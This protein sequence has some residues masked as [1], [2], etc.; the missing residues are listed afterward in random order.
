MRNPMAHVISVSAFLIISF[1]ASPAADPFVPGGPCTRG[2]VTL[3][4]QAVLS[5]WG[6]LLRGACWS[7][8]SH[9]NV[10]N[11]QDL[12]VLKN[13]GL[14]TIHLY[15]EKN[16]DKPV[17]FEV[18]HVDSIVEWCRQDSMYVILT[19]GNSYLQGGYDKVL[20]FW[21]FY[22]PRYKD[23]THVIY[24]EKNEG[25]YG[26]YHCEEAPMQC[27]RDCYEIIREIA[28][29]TH[30]M[31]MS[32]SNLQGGINPLYEDID[33]LGPEI[34]WTNASIAFHGYGTTGGFQEEAARKLGGDGY[35]MTCT[36]FFPNGGLEA[37]YESAAISYCHFIWCD[38]INGRS[39][40]AHCERIKPLNL[41]YE[42]DFG[43]WPRPHIDPPVVGIA[44]YG[45][46]TGSRLSQS[47]VSRLFLNPAL[48]RDAQAVYDLRGRLVWR[49]QPDMGSPIASS[50]P[51]LPPAATGTVLMVKKGP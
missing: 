15:A 51:C 36:E 39:I 27:Y 10:F 6:T 22:A 2:R 12:D 26:T 42:P 7:Q 17:G 5:D 8:D 9:G 20:E 48:P 34:D 29:E 45:P 41:S 3:D 46:T 16:D 19:F 37:A 35:A 18:E 11:R 25:C 43:N 44:S 31:M 28:P 4:A 47:A 24:E 33:R 23:M 50:E 1:C 40:E 14:N 21:R 30:V 32:H 38:W 13:C 49:N